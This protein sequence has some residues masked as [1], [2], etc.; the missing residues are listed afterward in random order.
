MALSKRFDDALVLASELHREQTR[1]GSNVPYISH[2][3]G[4]A[5]LVIEHG[6]DEDEAIAALL[7]DA[8]EDQGGLPTL[9]RIRE[10]F[11]EGVAE[12]V[13]GCTDAVTEPKPAWRGRKE[14]YI[15]HIREEATPSI[16]FVSCADKLHNA[17]AI[18]NDYR[19]HGDA[20]WDRFNADVDQLLWYYRS[21]AD[22]FMETADHALAREL[23]RVVREIEAEYRER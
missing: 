1:K 22:A 21:L 20:L 3:L 8:V 18:L 10:M 23:D 2:L 9:E 17:R 15:R 5:S 7:H 16:R 19:E 12:I 13:A 4:V 6:G 11:G 14:A